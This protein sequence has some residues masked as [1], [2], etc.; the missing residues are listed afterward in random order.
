MVKQAPVNVNVQTLFCFLPYVWIYAFYRIE[1]LRLG[2][3]VMLITTASSIVFQ[4]ILPFPYGL[5][6]AL[7]IYIILPVPIIRKWSNE[8]NKKFSDL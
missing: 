3:I 8:W 5:V 6:V 7:A 2:L 4:I 1:K